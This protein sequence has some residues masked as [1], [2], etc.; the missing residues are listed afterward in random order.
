VIPVWTVPRDER[1]VGT[2]SWGG[3]AIESN[4]DLPRLPHT[5][6]PED[7]RFEWRFE[8]PPHRS[9]AER[10]ARMRTRM[11]GLVHVDSWPSGTMRYRV[12][13]V[14]LFEVRADEGMIDFFAPETADPMQVEHFL[15]NAVLP[16]YA[17][18]RSVVCL[19]ASAVAVGGEAIVF[20]GPSGSGKSTKAW[21]ALTGGGRLLA[22]D[23]VVLRGHE[24]GWLVY[25]GSTTLRLVD[26]PI[27]P[28]WLL[29]PKQEARVKCSTTPVP[30]GDL[31]VLDRKGSPALGARRGVGL[32]R[33]LLALQPGWVWGDARGRRVIGDATAALCD[34]I[35]GETGE[36]E[37]S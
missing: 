10:R 19:H 6:A 29:G 22:D 2:Y 16:I 18:L 15:V 3:F 33:A 27:A 26:L 28:S 11:G 14:G 4:L 1:L 36:V 23:A 9:P 5:S 21:Q 17:G 7:V 32:L 8:A 35:L 25:P 12:E 24:Q 34:R 13:A 37:S 31:V 30:L 20:A